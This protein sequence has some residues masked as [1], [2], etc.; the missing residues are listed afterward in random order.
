MRQGLKLRAARRSRPGAACAP[1]ARSTRRLGSCVPPPHPFSKRMSGHSEWTDHAT[2][3][4][5]RERGDLIAGIIRRALGRRSLTRGVNAAEDRE[6]PMARR[7]P[8]PTPDL[9]PLKGGLKH[10]PFAALGGRSPSR[11]ASVPAS[12]PSVSRKSSEASRSSS[13]AKPSSTSP[14]NESRTPSSPERVTVR[15]ERAGRGGKTVTIAEGP[16]LAG[17]DLD[18]LARDIS[19]ALGLGARAEEGLI[20]VQ[21]DQ[22][23]RLA[24]W[25]ESRGFR[26]VARGN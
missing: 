18:V 5:H 1:I 15:Q 23:E 7:E 6:R 22:R 26:G 2:Q 10:N 13:T 25:L 20:V 24:E 9:D 4:R 17:S 21:G 3:H 11:D 16:G 12:Q 8:D 19:R 14:R